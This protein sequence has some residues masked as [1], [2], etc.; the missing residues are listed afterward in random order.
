MDLDYIGCVAAQTG[1]VAN[2]YPEG[3]LKLFPCHMQ[4]RP[5]KTTELHMQLRPLLDSRTASPGTCTS[6]TGEWWMARFQ[7]S[8]PFES[9]SRVIQR[10]VADFFA[11]DIGR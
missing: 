3:F 6:V 11:L 5:L 9:P 8:L 10:A 4:L 1:C 7:V 2:V